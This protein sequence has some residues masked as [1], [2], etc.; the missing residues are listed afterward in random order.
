MMDV[1]EIEVSKF[2]LVIITDS[3]CHVQR[4][5]KIKSLYPHSDF[6]CLGDI[7]DLFSNW[8]SFNKESVKYFMENK[9][10]CLEGNHESFIK[11]CYTNDMSVL[12]NVLINCNPPKFNLDDVHLDFLRA[13][14][15]GFKLNLPN[16]EHYLCFH[17]KPNDLW[18]F[19][20]KDDMTEQ[21]FNSSFPLT[22][23]TLGVIHGHLHKRFVKQYSNTKAQRYSVGAVKFKDYA[24]LTENGLYFKQL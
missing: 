17:N 9:I 7:T 10:P 11:A 2:P 1:K 20:E 8:E 3:H 14:P 15:R 16:G 18:G 6:I 4:I 5:S 21:Q 12:N 23:K 19:A 22:D 24:I 13:L